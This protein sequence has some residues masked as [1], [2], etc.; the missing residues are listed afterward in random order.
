[1]DGVIK[2][3]LTNFITITLIAFAGV[4]LLNKVFARFMPALQ[5]APSAS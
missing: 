5:A 3:N 1:M 4:W 2:V